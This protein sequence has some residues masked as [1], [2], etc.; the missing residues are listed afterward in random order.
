MQARILTIALR[1]LSCAMDVAHEYLGWKIHDDRTSIRANFEVVF[2]SKP[3]QVSGLHI[4]WMRIKGH[5]ST[6]NLFAHE[7]GTTDRRELRARSYKIVSLMKGT[8]W[9]ELTSVL[10]CLGASSEEFIIWAPVMSRDKRWSTDGQTVE[11]LAQRMRSILQ[12]TG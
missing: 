12:D 10:V 3:E 4:E 2:L 6:R 8:P 7:L 11:Y 1:R 5:R 9:L